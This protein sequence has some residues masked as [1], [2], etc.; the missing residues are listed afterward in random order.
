LLC[1]YDAF[2]FNFPFTERIDGFTEKKKKKKVENQ[3]T[4]QKKKG[5]KSF[6]YRY[7]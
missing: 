3:Q 1:F 7:T 2:V 6:L 4:N 5:T